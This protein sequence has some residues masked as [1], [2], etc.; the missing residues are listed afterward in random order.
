MYVYIYINANL[1]KLLDFRS[2][3]RILPPHPLFHR[4]LLAY[5]KLDY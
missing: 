4:I 3:R 1:N 2:S 5:L